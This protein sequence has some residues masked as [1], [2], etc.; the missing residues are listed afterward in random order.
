[1]AAVVFCAWPP[2][3]NCG[4]ASLR[5]ELV[6]FCNACMGGA[7]IVFYVCAP[8]CAYPLTYVAHTYKA[9]YAPPIKAEKSHKLS[10]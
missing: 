5:S 8:A 9:M 2:V 1:M 6:T 7:D 3:T 10:A 4:D